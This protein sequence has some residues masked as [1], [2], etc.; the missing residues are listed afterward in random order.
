MKAGDYVI[1]KARV[2]KSKLAAA[3]ARPEIFR[4]AC[5]ANEEH[6]VAVIHDNGVPPKRWKEN[7]SN[8]ALYADITGGD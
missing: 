6:T 4:L 5:C 3:A 1:T 8:I 2:H 7:V